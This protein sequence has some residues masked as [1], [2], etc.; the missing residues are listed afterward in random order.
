MGKYTEK[1]SALS[2]K[3]HCEKTSTFMNNMACIQDNLKRREILAKDVRTCLLAAFDKLIQTR[4]LDRMT[5][6]QICQTAGVSR[7]SFYYYFDD[8]VD[9]FSTYIYNVLDRQIKDYTDPINWVHGLDHILTFIQ[10]ERI[11]FRHIYYSKFFFDFKK[12][13]EKAVTFI[14]LPA[15]ETCAHRNRVVLCK[16]EIVLVTRYYQYIF[17]EIIL[18][19]IDDESGNSPEDIVTNCQKLMDWS[20]DDMIVRVA[21]SRSPQPANPG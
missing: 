18:H 2:G 9:L 15:V 3:N 10:N 5:I 4:S 14:L 11:K 6:R 7:Q 21:K 13:L 20:L 16:E 19:Y 12:A 17:V 8:I 1:V